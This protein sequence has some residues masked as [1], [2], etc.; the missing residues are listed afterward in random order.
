MKK[1]VWLKPRENSLKLNVDEPFLWGRTSWCHSD[2]Q[3]RRF[4][5][6]SSAYLP[7]VHSVAMVEVF[8]LPKGMSC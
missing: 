3:T 4:V 2:K 8:A 1:K 5:V 6:A 7:H